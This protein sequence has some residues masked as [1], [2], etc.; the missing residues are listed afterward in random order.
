MSTSIS[1][2]SLR[3]DNYQYLNDMI[4]M[5]LSIVYMALFTYILLSFIYQLNQ[6]ILN[7]KK[8]VKFEIEY[9]SDIEKK[10]RNQKEPEF[11]RILKVVFDSYTMINFGYSL[12]TIYSI[13][14][15]IRFSLFSRVLVKDYPI[16]P[17]LTADYYI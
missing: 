8:W 13:V 17:D 9:L 12:L 10:Q 14:E 5:G 11:I 7:Y 4:N 3:L 15:Y 1:A 2:R 16:W 6:K